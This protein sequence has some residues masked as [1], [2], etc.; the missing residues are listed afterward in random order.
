MVGAKRKEEVERIEIGVSE[1]V[2]G[3]REDTHVYRE[4]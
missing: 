4:Q 2:K 1:A 3:N